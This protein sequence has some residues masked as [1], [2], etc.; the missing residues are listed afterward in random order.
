MADNNEEYSN[1]EFFNCFMK[2]FNSKVLSTKKNAKKMNIPT[3]IGEFQDKFGTN[4]LKERL[5]KLEAKMKENM[6]N[7]NNDTVAGES[8]NGG[9]GGRKRKSRKRRRT[10]RKSK[11]KRGGNRKRKNKTRR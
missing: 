7:E 3:D 5:D 6:K 4:E 9:R 1:S 2:W 11:K 10:R 8:M